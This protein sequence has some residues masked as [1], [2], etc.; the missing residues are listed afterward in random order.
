M[1]QGI[2]LPRRKVGYD[3]DITFNLHMIA[4]KIVR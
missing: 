4:S 1:I 2:L 3:A